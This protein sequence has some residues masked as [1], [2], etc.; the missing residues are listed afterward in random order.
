MAASVSYFEDNPDIIHMVLE[1]EWTTQEWLLCSYQASSLIQQAPQSVRLLVEYRSHPHYY[2][3]ALFANLSYLGCSPLIRERRIQRVIVV[4]ENGI[5]HTASEIFRRVYRL[6]RVVL[7][8]DLD[9]AR[10]LLE[11]AAVF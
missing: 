3:P 8:S 10:S 7:A 4:G 2:P 5:L 11:L 1:G 6:K 9:Q